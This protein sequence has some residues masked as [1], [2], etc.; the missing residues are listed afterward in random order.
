MRSDDGLPTSSL[1]DAAGLDPRFRSSAFE[2]TDGRG[3]GGG[4]VP[5][6]TPTDADASRKLLSEFV[7]TNKP[8]L[9]KGSLSDWAPVLRWHDDEYLCAAEPLASIDVRRTDSS[10]RT[11]TGSSAYQ[12][13][14]SVSW[15]SLVH[16]L[17]ESAARRERGS[18]YAAQVHLRTVLPGL[19][20]DTRPVPP[21]IGAL[22][23]VW[24]NAPSL[25]FGC[26]ARTPLHFDLL[27]NVL[28]VVRGR[29]HVTLWHPADAALLYP[30]EAAPFSMADVYEPDLTAFPR[31]AEARTRG[32]EVEVGCGDALYIPV[33]WWHAVS[34]PQ[35]E[36][37]ISVSYW[38]Q[39]PQGKAAEQSP[40]DDEEEAGGEQGAGRD[41]H[42]P[43]ASA[44]QREAARSRITAST[45][46][47]HR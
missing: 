44:A 28:C 39:Q 9:L 26:G 30:C 38:A 7:A 46:S 13:E 31:L 21:C 29:K 23:P 1:L 16:E 18:L 22:G 14:S 47:V 37:S 42:D 10:G 19:F 11:S 27:E 43:K 15:P 12:R 17:A 36:R 34:T 6:V 4:P 45:F 41:Q 5:T 33:G 35:G 32:L 25:Y 40:F 3:H 24:R 2:N 8:V 20:A